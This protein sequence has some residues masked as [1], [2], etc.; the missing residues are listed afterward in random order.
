M[1]EDKAG[2]GCDSQRATAST[3]D[4]YRELFERSADAILI[5]E[6]DTFIDCNQ[7]TVEMLRYNNKTELLSTHPSELSPPIQ[8]DG[9][10]SYTKANEMIA[11]AMERGSHRFDWDHKRADGEVFPVEVL[12]TSVQEHDRQILHVVWRDISERKQLESQL[13]HAQKMEAIG[14]LAGGIA[15]DFNNLLVAIIGSGGM[16]EMHLKDQPRELKLVEQI[17]L[18]G[19][20]AAELVRQLLAF[21]RKQELALTVININDL[22]GTIRGLLERLI[23]EDITL[24]LDA[25]DE[26]LHVKVDVGQI[27]QVLLNLASNAHD[28]MPSGGTV[29]ISTRRVVL[30]DSTIGGASATPGAY[31][32]ISVSD[33]GVGMNTTTAARAFDPFFTTKALGKGTGL[34]LATVYGIIKQIGGNTEIFSSPGHGTTIKTYLPLTTE[35]CGELERRNSQLP[36]RGGT[37]TILVAEDDQSVINLVVAVL[38]EKGYTVLQAHDG[39]EALALYTSEHT[40][41]DLVITDVVMPKMSGPVWVERAATTCPRPKALFMSGY[42]DN[43]LKQLRS[44]EASVDL[45]EKPFSAGELVGR[46]RLALDR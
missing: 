12:L 15:H 3:P 37:E 25:C 10:D 45:L 29:T 1:G 22:V 38:C 28:A 30:S 21:G 46:V 26:P 24:T 13:R 44:G 42:T 9:R 40:S 34:G 23:G 35:T 14:K 32:A 39:E 36:T 5:I 20:R 43:A 7:A 17:L 33:T 8:P 16:L 27:E 2:R 4:T 19:D 18:A 41:I 11:I 31:A 6:G